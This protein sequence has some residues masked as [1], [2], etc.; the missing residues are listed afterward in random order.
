MPWHPA[1]V[2]FWDELST[3]ER[4]VLTAALEEAPL[5]SVIADFLGHA[6]SGGAVWTFGVDEGEIRALIPRFAA[7]V[8]NM[9]RRELIEI[10][11][12]AN[13]VWDHAVP[14]TPDEIRHTLADPAT[15]ICT[16]GLAKRMVWLMTT[17]HADRLIGRISS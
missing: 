11:E 15:W 8:G 13:G 4:C 12:P 7:V 3:E 1:V 2:T 16:D 9:I 14:M 10:R 6:E 17:A 5:N